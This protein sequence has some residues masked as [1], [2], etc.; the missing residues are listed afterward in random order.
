M[1]TW[2]CGRVRYCITTSTRSGTRTAGTRVTTRTVQRTERTTCCYLACT[3]RTVPRFLYKNTAY[4]IISAQGGTILIKTRKTKSCCF[5]RSC[6]YRCSPS[7][8]GNKERPVRYKA[9]GSRTLLST[10]LERREKDTQGML[11]AW[12]KRKTFRNQK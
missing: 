3:V 2:C 6:C 9:G 7:S 12:P 8:S 4:F 1:C 10:V 11:T 5:S